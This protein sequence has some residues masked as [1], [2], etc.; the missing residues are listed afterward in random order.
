MK[1]L[2]HNWEKQLQNSSQII[3][4]Q[5]IFCNLK[6][7][8]FFSGGNSFIINLNENWSNHHSLTL[9]VQWC[10][11]SRKCYSLSNFMSF[12]LFLFSR[13][14]VQWKPLCDRTEVNMCGGGGVQFDV[15]AWKCAWQGEHVVS[16]E[17]QWFR[18]NPHF[19]H[20]CYFTER[21][22]TFGNKDLFFICNSLSD[23]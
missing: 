9:P 19:S 6:N 16:G 3:L 20:P 15:L 12:F 8:V 11:L 14:D 22:R 23:T 17:P 13:C 4:S 5:I 2:K 1:Q 18:I 21:W 7:E 10:L